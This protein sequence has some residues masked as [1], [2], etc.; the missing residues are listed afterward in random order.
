MD[1]SE[2]AVGLTGPQTEQVLATA[3]SAPSLRNSQRWQFR[4]TPHSIALVA[5]RERRLPA[6]DPDDRELRIACGAALFGLRPALR[7][8]R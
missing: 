2:A 7:G 1:E 3:G 5:D 6:T 8:P 4:L